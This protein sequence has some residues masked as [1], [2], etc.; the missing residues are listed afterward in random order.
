MTDFSPGEHLDFFDSTRSRP[1]PA[2]YYAGGNC[3]AVFSVG[4]G[5]NRD[6]YSYL[7]RHWQ[8]L[9]FS[10]LVVEHAG[11]GVEA[12]R[13]LNRQGRER[14]DEL[15][16]RRVVDPIEVA[17]RP[18]DVTFALS[19]LA[20]RDGSHDRVL[21]AGHSF[22]SFTV[23][24]LAGLPIWGRSRYSDARVEAGLAISP[25]P[26]GVHF[27]PESYAELTMPMLFLTGTRD[28]V[29][30]GVDYQARLESFRLA[31]G[32]DQHLVVLEGAEHLAFA[33]VGLGL[34]PILSQ[35]K[36]VTGG[37]LES[38]REGRPFEP[39]REVRWEQRGIGQA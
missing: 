4:F 28:E 35:V 16:W 1:V 36:A 19:A 2:T 32:P 10:V 20:E 18:R 7:A 3:L 37:Y 39:P 30:D 15:L 17:H 12:L 33:N 27:Y 5:G 24:A 25:T 29:R 22:G 11:S 8:S 14:R 9:N 38:W 34:G 31:A 23:L 26:P 21:A 13:E 6:G